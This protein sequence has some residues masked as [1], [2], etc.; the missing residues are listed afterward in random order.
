MINCLDYI[1][2]TPHTG[3]VVSITAY[4]ASLTG[5]IPVGQ[6]TASYT[7]MG[8][9]TSANIATNLASNIGTTMSNISVTAS[10]TGSVISISTSPNYC[11]QFTCA[12]TGAGA[13]DTISL[14]SSSAISLCISSFITITIVP[15]IEWAYKQTVPVAS[16][17]A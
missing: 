3:D 4:D 16:L 7:V 1:S 13:T 5:T 15:V 8:G 12:V 2:G 17:L 11:T 14:S 9:D 10:A 6:E